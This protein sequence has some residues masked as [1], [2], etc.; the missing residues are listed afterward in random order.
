MLSYEAQTRARERE[1]EFCV[2][3]TLQLIQKRIH[4]PSH[5]D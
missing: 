4:T 5:Y 2:S 1:K 3:L